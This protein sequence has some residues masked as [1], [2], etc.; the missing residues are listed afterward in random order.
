MDY[1]NMLKIFYF[2]YNHFYVIKVVVFLVIVINL[3]ANDFHKN[4]QTF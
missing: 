4:E 2:F 3:L 1:N